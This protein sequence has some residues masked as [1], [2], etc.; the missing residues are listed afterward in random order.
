MQCLITGVVILWRSISW[1]SIIASFTI[2]FKIA[3]TRPEWDAIL[4]SPQFNCFLGAT[5]PLSYT[6]F[7]IIYNI[8]VLTASWSWSTKKVVSWH[9]LET[10]CWTKWRE[11]ALCQTLQVHVTSDTQKIFLIGAKDVVMLLRHVSCHILTGI[12]LY[13]KWPVNMLL[14]WEYNHANIGNTLVLTRVLTE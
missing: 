6:N 4:N 3:S 1:T 13:F 5:Q 9:P 10:G 11:S 2:V 12:R 14:K 7:N 8:H